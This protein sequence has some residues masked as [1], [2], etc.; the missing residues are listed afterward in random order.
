MHCRE[1]SFNHVVA[2]G[3]GSFRDRST[4]FVRR[5]P[6]VA[7]LRGVKIAQFSDFGIFSPY[8]TP[9]TYLPVTRSQPRGYIAEWLRFFHVVVEGSKGCLPAAVFSCDFRYGSWRPQTC[10][11]FRLWQMA[12]PMQNATTRHVRSGPKMS[13][14]AQFWGRMYFLMKY[15]RS[16][17]PKSP[18]NPIFEDLSRQSL[19][20]TELS[21]SRT[22]MELRSWNFTDI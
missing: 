8:K 3:P 12:I 2:Q 14:N 1:I 6:T 7:E 11:N 19:L 20:Y 10:P 21:V 15:R 9:K 5:R 17:P 4:F 18:Q 13:E 22:L 16:Y